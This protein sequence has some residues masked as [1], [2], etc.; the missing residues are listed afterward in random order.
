MIPR[1]EQC[2][3]SQFC[4]ASFH[5]TTLSFLLHR[6]LEQAAVSDHGSVSGILGER[7]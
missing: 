5:I 7:P 6:L 3:S 4:R 2:D 1:P